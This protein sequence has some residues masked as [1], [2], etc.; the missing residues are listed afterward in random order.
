[1]IVPC[2]EV[3]YMEEIFKDNSEKIWSDD[4]SVRELPDELPLTRKTKR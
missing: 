1:M 3:E 2:C 4:T